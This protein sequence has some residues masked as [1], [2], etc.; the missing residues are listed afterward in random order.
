M[1]AFKNLPLSPLSGGEGGERGDGPV[2]QEPQINHLTLP[3]LQRGPLPLP[4]KAAERGFP[5][6]YQVR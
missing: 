4:R 5:A 3:R 2:A 6:V 1:R